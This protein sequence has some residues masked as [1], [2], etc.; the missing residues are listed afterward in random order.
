[1]SSTH[2]QIG[3]RKRSISRPDESYGKRGGAIE[4]Q[5]AS[6]LNTATTSTAESAA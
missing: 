2:I 1:V 3:S 4:K 5:G 6:E